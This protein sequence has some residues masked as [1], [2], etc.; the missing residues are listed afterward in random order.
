M[1]GNHKFQ[2]V[3]RA[4]LMTPENIAIWDN[5]SVAVAVVDG[6]GVCVYMNRIQRQIDG[7]ADVEVIGKHFSE[8]YLPNNMLRIPTL[9][10]LRLGEPILRKAYTYRTVDNMFFETVTDFFPLFDQGKKD[11]V[12]VFCIWRKDDSIYGTTGRPP[13][14]SRFSTEDHT[15]YTFSSIIGNDPALQNIIHDAQVAAGNMSNVMI[16]G[17]SG[18]GKEL[19][20]QSIHAASSRKDH[21]FVPVNCA[22]IPE[23]LLEGILF[24]T[25]KGA[26]T[27]ALDS[28]GLFE[29]AN[30]GT[31]LLDELNSMPL[32][33]QAK[34]LRVLQ[35]KKIRRVGSQREKSI[36][37]RVISILN[38]SPLALVEQGT[39]R[40]DLYYRLAVI[41][42]AVPPLRERR[43][44][45]P[46]LIESFLN[47]NAPK[48]KVSDAVMQMFQDWEWPGNIRELLHTLESSLAL[49]GGRSI[50]DVEVLP[51]Q[52]CEAYHR[53]ITENTKSVESSLF[54]ASG[55]DDYSN[56]RRNS[57]IP[58][59]DKLNAFEAQCIRNV[60]KVTGG[61][62]SKAARIMDL[63][64]AG[65]R[66]K[67]K[68]LG[69]KDDDY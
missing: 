67:I 41:G 10:C 26:Y 24:G 19:F 65:L 5:L 23:N 6:S 58:L 36:D 45:I 66:Y 11:G 43:K 44:D 14:P 52:F 21:P 51:R 39:L 54:T 64:G 4:E 40:L 42:L 63:T 22:A 46:L 17:E 55:I 8:L 60:L 29:K 68:Q 1:I 53:R 50:I 56:V 69:I 12:L 31:L 2:Y 62:V 3:S 13:A 7:F 34:L 49:L 61:N 9:E 35:E 33:L 15:R 38:E 20:A 48:V 18:T 37:V 32:G 27:G 16:W 47:E 30:G 25:V 59:K 28:A 57:V